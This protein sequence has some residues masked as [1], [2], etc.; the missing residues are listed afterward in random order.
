MVAAGLA[1]IGFGAWSIVQGCLRLPAY[2]WAVAVAVTAGMIV[3]L[4]WSARR[5]RAA[6]ALVE[7]AEA[8]EE[9]AAVESLRR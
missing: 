3:F 1:F 5:E 4:A 7:S 6:A 9:P 8:P 2:A